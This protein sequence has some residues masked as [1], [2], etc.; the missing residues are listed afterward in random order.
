M[1]D[2]KSQTAQDRHFINVN[3]RYEVEHWSKKFGVTEEAL[4]QAVQ[5]AGTSVKAVEEHLRKG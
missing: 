2:D 5:A 1:A 3:E 4:R